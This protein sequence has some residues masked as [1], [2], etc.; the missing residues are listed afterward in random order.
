M[1][2]CKGTTKKRYQCLHWSL[3]SVVAF[4]FLSLCTINPLLH[5]DLVSQVKQTAHR[6][7]VGHCSRPAAAQQAT[8]PLSADHEGTT[9]PVC[10]E[11]VRTHKTTS[12][13]SAQSIPLPMLTPALLPLDS[14][15]VGWRVEGL[16]LL[17]TLHPALSSPLYLLH[18][19]LLI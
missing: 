2:D 6:T 10:C 14:S 9:V 18:A 19:T 5:A 7:A 11:L 12:A 8:N 17:D 16:F 1:I 3:L 13:S 15:L 4:Y